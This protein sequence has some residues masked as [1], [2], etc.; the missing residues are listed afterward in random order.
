MSDEQL[1]KRRIIVP[2][3]HTYSTGTITIAPTPHALLQDAMSVISAE[4]IK[5]KFK[6]GQDNKPL[7]QHDAKTLQGYVRS[8]TELAREQRA[9]DAAMNLDELSDEDLLAL[10]TN[11]QQKKKLAKGASK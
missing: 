8:L 6:S 10:T 11:L 7:N 3:L 9:E 5:L 1:P 4:I 2:Q